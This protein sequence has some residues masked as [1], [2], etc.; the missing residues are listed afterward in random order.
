MVGTT[1]GP[2]TQ[3]EPLLIRTEGRIWLRSGREGSIQVL[4]ST[5]RRVY[6]SID[7]FAA[8]D[9]LDNSTIYNR[10]PSFTYA[11][12]V[13]YGAYSSDPAGFDSWAK[14]TVDPEEIVEVPWKV[15]VFSRP[16]IDGQICLGIT[17]LTSEGNSYFLPYR[18]SFFSNF[19]YDDPERDQYYNIDEI[20]VSEDGVATALSDEEK[21]LLLTTGAEQFHG[22]MSHVGGTRFLLVPELTCVTILGFKRC[23]GGDQIITP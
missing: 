15:D 2:S 21:Q 8:E 5:N 10:H 17:T 6:V 14:T 18:V 9:C 12:D 3:E 1:E 11:D 7:P 13:A 16:E 23:W 22:W 19:L 4:N 20:S